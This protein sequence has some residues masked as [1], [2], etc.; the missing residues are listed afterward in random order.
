MEKVKST[1][2]REQI[3]NNA[4]QQIMIGL[5]LLAARGHS[6]LSVFTVCVMLE[7]TV[8]TMLT[9]KAQTHFA[10]DLPVSLH[11][12]LSHQRSIA[13]SVKLLLLMMGQ[14]GLFVIHYYTPPLSQLPFTLQTSIFP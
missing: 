11:L 3:F 10:F 8:L 1:S 12:L 4:C 14:W 6:L 5:F 13:A 9:R 7:V 2:G